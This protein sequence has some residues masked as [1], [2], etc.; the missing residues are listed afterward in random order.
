VDNDELAKKLEILMK[1]KLFKE[2]ILGEYIDATAQKLGSSFDGNS[3]TVN[4]LMAITHL[5]E[6]ID[7]TIEYAKISRIKD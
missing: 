7:T 2:V 6:W 1:D 4:T 3:E 5:K